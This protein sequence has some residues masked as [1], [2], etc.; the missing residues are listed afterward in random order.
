M[1]FSLEG[2]K[3]FEKF[4]R[5]IDDNIS[6]FG[7]AMENKL[8]QCY[9]DKLS[10]EEFIEG[11]VDGMQRII[12]RLHNWAFN[13]L[14]SDPKALERYESAME[15]PSRNGFRFANDEMTI[16]K[17]YLFYV[18]GKAK[19]KASKTDCIKLERRAVSLIGKQCLDLG[20]VQ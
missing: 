9:D 2:K 13:D 19:K 3:S 18:W 6:V 10:D 17:V 11:Y 4:S 16:G 15:N 12:N 5:L 1:L 8:T 20:I 7:D 14:K